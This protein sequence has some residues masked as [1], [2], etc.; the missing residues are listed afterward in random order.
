VNEALYDC[1]IVR[2]LLLAYAG[3]SAGAKTIALVEMHLETCASCR[4]EL[5]SL[6]DNDAQATQIGQEV[7]AKFNK[8]HSKKYKRAVLRAALLSLTAVIVVS[9]LLFGVRVPVAI[10]RGDIE[11][12][13]NQSIDPRDDEFSVGWIYFNMFYYRLPGTPYMN[14]WGSTH[15]DNTTGTQTEYTFYNINPRLVDVLLSPFGRFYSRSSG[16]SRENPVVQDEEGQWQPKYPNV[17]WK[18]YYYQSRDEGV[19]Y[20]TVFAEGREGPRQSLLDSEGNLK[21]EVAEIATLLWEG[22]VKDDPEH[23]YVFTEYQ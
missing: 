14:V 8:R 1:E 4:E 11:L 7:L 17:I 5:E 23:P 6:R 22:P 12:T 10:T 20:D 21:P 13:S 19:L 9:A 3:Q 18:V 15:Y 16:Y 2:D